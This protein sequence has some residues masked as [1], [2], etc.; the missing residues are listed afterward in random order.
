MKLESHG[1]TGKVS[2]WVREWL[3]ERMQRV[4]INGVTSSWLEVMSGVPQG[5]V[6]GPI[7]FLIYINDFDNGIKNWILKFA[8]DTKIFSAVNND[9]DRRLFQIDLDDLL[10]WAEEWQIMFSVSKCKVMHLG[11]KNHGYSYSV[12]TWI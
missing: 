2:Q 12:I 4:C 5:S 6:L 3:K 1:I 9:S 10:M 11:H 7:L 8:D